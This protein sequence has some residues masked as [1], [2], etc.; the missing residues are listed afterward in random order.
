[1]SSVNPAFGE[2]YDAVKHAKHLQ[3]DLNIAHLT[4]IQRERLT[5]LIKKY[6]RVFSKAGVV[7]P[8]KDYVCDIDTGSARPICCRNPTFGPLETP[9]MEHAMAKLLDLG[10]IR[11]IIDGQWLSKPLLAPKPHQ[12]NVTSIDNFVWRFCVNYAPLNTVT[13]VVAMPIPRC[14]EA[15]GNTFGNAKF[16]WLMDAISGYNQLRVTESSQEK[17]AFAGPDCTKYTYTVMPFGPINGPVIF[18]VFIHDMNSTWNELARRRGLSLNTGTNTRVI[19][20]D[21]FSWAQTFDNFLLYLE[22][23]LQVCLS[24]NLSLSLKKCLFCPSRIEFV[25]VDVTDDG[26]CP[27]MSKHEF[28]RAFPA[29]NDVRDISS[30]LGFVNFYAKWVPLFEQRAEP[31][32]AIIKGK[33]QTEVILPLMGPL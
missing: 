20:D 33:E 14:D 26:N 2:E 1:M 29:F 4:L 15:V 31:L 22:C 24:Q 17:L 30:F 12:E 21:I 7:T 16:R 6:Y 25:G 19:V 8:V 27:A 3:S 10:H 28:L 9:V 5:S 32:R 18:I 11:Q 23:Q 13:R